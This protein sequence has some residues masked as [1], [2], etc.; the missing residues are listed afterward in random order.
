M[1]DGVIDGWSESEGF[2][3]GVGAFSFDTVYQMG[4]VEDLKE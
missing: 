1:A 4:E 2:R 3:N